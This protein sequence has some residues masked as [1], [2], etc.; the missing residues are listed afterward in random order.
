MSLLSGFETVLLSECQEPVHGNA[1]VRLVELAGV[2]DGAVAGVAHGG[3]LIEE[4]VEEEEDVVVGEV[5]VW[6]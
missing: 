4:A 6:I 3:E 5:G 1:G 2:R